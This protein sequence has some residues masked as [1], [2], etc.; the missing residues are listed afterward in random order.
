MITAARIRVSITDPGTMPTRGVEPSTPRPAPRDRD[1]AIHA[2]AR[3]RALRLSGRV[4]LMGSWLAGVTMA[5]TLTASA[6]GLSWESGWLVVPGLAPHC[7]SL[8]ASPEV[9][10]PER[11]YT[12]P[13][14]GAP[15]RAQDES[16]STWLLQ[17][18]EE[19]DSP[20]QPL[21]RKVSWGMLKLRYRPSPHAGSE[22]VILLPQRSELPGGMPTRPQGRDQRS[23]RLAGAV[24]R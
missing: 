22:R 7:A 21:R 15:H 19:P 5:G 12:A 24:P 9:G 2:S 16:D 14:Q 17:D 13:L 6:A 8:A 18:P 1:L 20:A 4:L 11:L 3:R 10:T 23:K